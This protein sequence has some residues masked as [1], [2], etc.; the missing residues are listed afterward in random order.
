MARLLV[1]DELWSVIEPIIPAKPRR[2]RNAGRK[3]I[4]NRQ[5]LTGILFVLKTGIAWES[6]PREMG[7]GSGV[8]CWRRLRDW[9]F[10]GVWQRLHLVLLERLHQAD[11]IDWSRVVVDSSSVRAPLGGRRPDLAP[12]IDGNSAA[13]TTS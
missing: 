9:Q 5:T 8:T 13:S 10:G 2:K 11:A 1:D 12:L 3:P 7:C 4:G 6:L